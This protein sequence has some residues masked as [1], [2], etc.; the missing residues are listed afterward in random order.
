[1]KDIVVL[2][3]GGSTIDTLSEQFFTNIASLKK[4]GLNLIVVHGGGPAIK[5]ML[6]TLNVDTVFVDGLR[7]TTAPI[8]DVVEQVLAG[9]VN[10]ALTAKLNYA[11]ISSV[12]LSGSDAK[13]MTAKAKN[14]KRY[15]YVGEITDVNAAFLLQLIGIG[16]TP[17]IAPIAIGENGVRYNINADTAA[18]AV[19]KAIG[20]EKLIFVTDVP[21]VMQDDKLLD[22]ITDA[23]SEQ[24]IADGVIHGGMIPKVRAAVESL[25]D[26]LPEVMI[27]DG[28]QPKLTQNTGL[29]GTVI[30]KSI[31]VV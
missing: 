3:C 5:E 21:G 2:K 29:V 20:A 4:A 30:K 17:V 14:F 15:G 8:M 18:G 22:F 12:G 28:N 1:M 13:L 10:N 16:I 27:V 24:L 19:A 25:H 9:K 31:G 26:N 7:K 11:G 23:D 6:T